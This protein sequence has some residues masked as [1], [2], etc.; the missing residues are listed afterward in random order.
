MEKEPQKQ[1]QP[2]A[3]NC[4]GYNGKEET[5]ATVE[6]ERERGGDKTG[7][8]QTFLIRRKQCK[9]SSSRIPVSNFPIFPLSYLAPNPF[10]NLPG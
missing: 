8:S 6:E 1:Q 4:I 9:S 5:D 2:I 10:A 7:L 3:I